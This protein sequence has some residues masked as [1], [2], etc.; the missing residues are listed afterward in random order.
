MLLDNEL[1]AER[2]IQLTR[3][4]EPVALAY[5]IKA[6]DRARQAS[7]GSTIKPLEMLSERCA[8]RWRELTTEGY[9]EYPGSSDAVRATIG[10]GGEITIAVEIE[11]VSRSDAALRVVSTPERLKRLRKMA[12]K[13]PIPLPV[14]QSGRAIRRMQL[15][16][17]EKMDKYLDVY[18]FDFEAATFQGAS[19]DAER[20]YVYGAA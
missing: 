10:T 19:C 14:I 1:V 6:L 17:K 3:A 18:A 4:S 20:Q 2:V 13:A 11:V 12:D 15:T 7:S 8:T 16:T 9:E 5:R